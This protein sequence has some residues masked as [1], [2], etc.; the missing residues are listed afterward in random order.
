VFRPRQHG[1]AL[2]F[3]VL[4]CLASVAP[5]VS[6]APLDSP[7]PSVVDAGES[8]L[9]TASATTSGA[10]EATTNATNAALQASDDEI[11]VATELSLTPN[12][13]GSVAVVQT[14]TVPDRVPSLSVTLPREAEVTNANGFSRAGDGSWEWSGSGTPRLGYRL[15][16]NETSP[17]AGPLGGEG[18]YVFADTGDWALVRRP[19]VGLRW[20]QRGS[21]PVTV[22]RSA[23]VAGEGVV[24][25]E[26]AFL[27]A[28]RVLTRQAHD[29]TF[30]LVVPAAA[31]MDEEPAQV[32]AALERASGSLHVGDRDEEVFVV[33]APTEGVSWAVQGLQLGDSDMWVQDDE[34]VA[35]VENVWVHE[36]VHTR[37][38]FTTEPSAQWLTEATATWYAARFA[39]RDDRIDFGTFADF[40]DRGA[41]GPQGRS[42]LAEPSSWQNAAQYLKGGLV[43]GD[44]DRRIRVASDGGASLQTVFRWLNG[45]SEPVSNA[46]F[47]AA[48]VEAGG[49]DVR[50]PTRRFTT[51]TDAPEMW[52]R[53][54]H[55][56]VFES[57]PAQMQVVADPSTVRV[58]GPYREGR[59][60]DPI[61]LAAGETLSLPVQVEN[62]GGTAGEYQVALRVDDLVVTTDSGSLTAGTSTT[63][64]LEHTFDQP[65]EYVV[66]IAGERLTVEVVEPAAPTVR[67][68]RADRDRVALGDRV[69]VTAVVENRGAVPGTATV[70]FTRDGEVV[71]TREVSLL[72]GESQE[73]TVPVRLTES[74][75]HRVGAGDVTVRVSVDDDVTGAS[76]GSGDSTG[77]GDGESTSSIPVPGLGVVAGVVGVL[78]AA[79]LIGRRS[80]RTE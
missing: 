34:R 13:P 71:A 44:V 41:V 14:F 63:V 35:D 78:V 45:R 39:L 46:D 9:R 59:L 1:P 20:R 24:G 28:H 50:P 56:A 52:D 26:T 68:V 65:G 64:R 40:L 30:R 67:A 57:I 54:A 75:T 23:T 76:G 43:V 61:L 3:T 19:N 80:E 33:V 15:P 53:T 27:G 51:T 32:F 72:A 73:V 2:L 74:G 47:V 38:S 58:S 42:V 12:R 49:G 21:D 5:V 11:R 17:Q 31:E 18:A 79:L 70:E 10:P 55:A 6:A 8:P 69:Q 77:D 37:Q 22:T 60:G 16:A 36:Y 29:Q 66:S 25:G 48:V 7:S 62:V 4:L